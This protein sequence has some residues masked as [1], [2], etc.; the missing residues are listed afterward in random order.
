MFVLFPMIHM[1]IGLALVFGSDSLR[2][3]KPPAA[4]A[5]A[6]P[7]WFTLNPRR[8]LWQRLRAWLVMMLLW[9][10]VGALAIGHYFLNASPPYGALAWIASLVYL[11]LGLLP[12]WGWLYHFLLMR[13]T[14]D[15]IVMTSADRFRPGQSFNVRLVHPMHRETLIQSLKLGLV[16]D[17]HVEVKTGNKTR[18]NK[19]VDFED[20][21]SVLE[22][23][24]AQAEETIQQSVRFTIPQDCPAS[25]FTKQYPRYEW[26]IEVRA[27]LKDSP[28]YRAE[29]MI[30]V[31][32]RAEG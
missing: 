8:S 17:K 28:D 12:G 22:N 32:P 7:G 21:Q 2:P 1:S 11:V 19:V 27:A 6:T 10:S 16:R 29:Y 15:P 31:E 23:H 3:A 14:S 20:W 9:Y 30:L 4:P 25:S 5:V 18:Y 24:Q 26:K 13:R